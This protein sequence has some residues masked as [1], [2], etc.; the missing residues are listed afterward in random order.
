MPGGVTGGRLGYPVIGP[1][2][3]PTYG[4]GTPIPPDKL[5]GHKGDKKGSK[6][7]SDKGFYGHMQVGSWKKS[8]TIKGGQNGPCCKG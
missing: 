6:G 5:P 1:M 3:R 8:P 7:K 2:G 4:D